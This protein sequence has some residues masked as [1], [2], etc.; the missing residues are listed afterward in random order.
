V[1]GEK[2]LAACPSEGPHS[3]LSFEIIRLLC[4]FQLE[5]KLLRLL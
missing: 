2:H 4:E 1:L 5:R 3:T